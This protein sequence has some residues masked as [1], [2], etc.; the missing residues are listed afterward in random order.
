MK[1]R[2]KKVEILL[3][4]ST[5]KNRGDNAIEIPFCFIAISQ[6]VSEI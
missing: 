4:E 6:L 3:S 2:E 1:K 5:Q